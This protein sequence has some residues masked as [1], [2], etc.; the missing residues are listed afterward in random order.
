MMNNRPGG[1]ATVVLCLAFMPAAWSAE[2]AYK[3]SVLCDPTPTMNVPSFT[4]PAVGTRD[5]DRLTVSRVVYRPN[6]DEEVARSTGTATMVQG[7]VTIDLSTPSGNLSGRF[8]GTVTDQEIALSG[9][10]TVKPAAGG[11]HQRQCRI[12]L[13]RQ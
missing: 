4:A 6:T 1:V 5:G 12:N 9:T 13:S 3:G 11:V 10:E 2:V 8:T 7:K